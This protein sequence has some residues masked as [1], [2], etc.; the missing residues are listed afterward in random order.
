MGFTDFESFK[1][2]FEKYALDKFLPGWVWLGLKQ[3][4]KLVITA[5]NNEDNCLMQGVAP[6]N[7]TPIL[8]LDM[9]EHA[10]FGQQSR[11]EYVANFWK[12]VDWEKVSKQFESHTK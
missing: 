3:D 7:C 10:Y 5:T 12:A 9:W 11:E 2:H 6:V 4:G 8:A 1:S